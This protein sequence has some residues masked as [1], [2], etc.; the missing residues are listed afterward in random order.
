[1]RRSVEIILVLAALGGWNTAAR[2]TPLALMSTAAA[3]TLPSVWVNKITKLTKN[4]NGTRQRLAN[5][6]T[7]I[8]GDDFKA[9]Q[10]AKL[11]DNFRTSLSRAPESNDAVLTEAQAVLSALEAEFAAA[12]VGTPAPTSE[13]APAATTTTT[14]RTAAPTPTPAAP[15]SNVRPLVSGERVRVKKMI[16][17]MTN[18][19]GSITTEGPSLYQDPLEYNAAVK[20]FGQ[21]TD[22]LKKYPQAEDPDVKAARDT[23]LKLRASLQAE[24]TRGKEQYDILGDVP[25]NL[26]ALQNRDK[27]YPIPAPLSPPFDEAQVKVW[28]AASRIAREAAKKDYKYITDI[29]P[30]AYLPEFTKSGRKA[31]FGAKDL[32]RLAKL[33]ENRYDKANNGYGLIKQKIKS[34]LRELDQQVQTPTARTTKQEQMRHYAAFA[35]MI[36]V[37]ESAVTL[38]RVIGRPTDEAEATV[39]AVKA[40]REAYDATFEDAIDAVRMPKAVSSDAERLAIAKDILERPRYEFG[41]HGPILL[42]TS[43]ILEKERKESEIEIDDVEVYGGEIRMSGTKETTVWKWRE[44][45]FATALKEDDSDLW[46]IYYIKPKFHLL[47]NHLK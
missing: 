14:A 43:E 6:P 31:E 15:A 16:R 34:A 22:A 4:I 29:Q 23:Y 1:M 38:E 41:E 39:A 20:R 46:R 12:K 8:T 13:P 47:Q 27:E 17:D 36:P 45:Q 9:N 11:I 2:D 3:E 21:F 40:R 37:A 28:L 42:N 10:F 32:P 5:D 7:A 35:D 25:A 33:T 19:L 30:I 44:F 24:L 18:V 26:R